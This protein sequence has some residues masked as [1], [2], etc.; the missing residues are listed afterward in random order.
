MSSTQSLENVVSADDADPLVDF[1][2]EAGAQDCGHAGGRTLLD[3]LLGTRE[4]L[5]RWQVPR[6]LQDVGALHSVYSTDVY[7]FQLVP[8][9]RRKDVRALVGVRAE[10]LAWLFCVLPR[11][12]LFAAADR[13][14]AEGN[15]RFPIENR[16]GKVVKLSRTDLCHL[17][18]VHMA[19]EG[20]QVCGADGG[21]GLWLARV[22][23]LGSK[24]PRSAISLPQVFDSCTVVVSGVHERRARA[25]Y[26]A[27]IEAL[28]EPA[29]AR[30]SFAVASV[31][32]PWVGEPFVW[33]AYAALREGRSE[34]ALM[35]SSHAMRTME[36]LGIAWDK[37]LSFD[38][39]TSLASLLHEAATAR[40]TALP[41]FDLNRPSTVLAD[42]SASLARATPAATPE[43]P[44]LDGK[45][46]QRF[47]AYVATFAARPRIHWLGQYPGLAKQAWHDPARFPIVASLEDAFHD[48]RHEIGSV[49]ATQFHREAE[50]IGRTGSWDVLMFYERGRKNVE[51]CS[52]CPITA[53]IIERAGAIRTLPGLIYASRL[54]PGTHINAHQGP[55]NIRVRCHLPLLVPDGDCA[56]RVGAETRRWEEGRC[57]VFDDS[58]DHE[59][60]NHGSGDRIVLIVDLW[61]PDLSIE[62]IALLRGLHHYAAVQAASLNNYWAAN[63][64][65]RAEAY[66]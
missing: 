33:R 17:L 15:E 19:N 53:E 8:K 36:S 18:V 63:A 16:D 7:K 65:A 61:H 29:T 14:R 46:A 48:I 41:P 54:K 66:H 60:W 59:A 26:T 2:R 3:H 32:C 31:A 22:S 13:L 51:A 49:D 27:G 11:S 5:R 57:V 43:P 39:W 23:L 35:W 44:V 45:D 56:I 64:R 42:L 50:P 12:D 40:A 47:H 24:L 4:V 1:L 20:E 38:Q 55:T 52:R 58:L 30:D 62:E 25:A 21:P 37:R 6:W 28:G 9:A 10:R 34:D